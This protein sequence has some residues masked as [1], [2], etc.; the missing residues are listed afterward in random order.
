MHLYDRVFY[1]YINV[2]AIRS[3]QALLPMV[4]R[5]VTVGSVA[6][7]GAG[8]GA[9]LS[10]WRDLGVSD[11]T[12]LDGSYVDQA[13]LLVPGDRF[14]PV[15]LARRVRLGRTFDLVQSL[16]F[17]EHL[18]S[19]AAEQFVDNLVAHSSVVLF[20]AAVPGQGG[21]HHVNEKPHGYWRGLF[22][23]RDYV[24][25]DVIRPSLAGDTRVE[26]WY[27]Y[28]TF[29]YVH[30]DHLATLP[31]ATQ[32][33]QVGDSD[34]IPDFSPPIHRLRKMIVRTLPVWAVN[35]LAVLKKHYYARLRPKGRLR[36]AIPA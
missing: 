28:N 5:H 1:E 24:M 6:D 11:V 20:S 12:A 7:F 36:V 13:A 25:L 18:P 9:W 31:A 35:E 16:E 4:A 30:R 15:D 26:P 27:R 32:L 22:G 33:F 3:A 21:E 34:S 29:V 19:S 17:A 8:Q 10:V 14:V 2:G 23:A